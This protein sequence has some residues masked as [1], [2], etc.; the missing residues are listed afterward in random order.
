MQELLPMP[1]QAS[2]TMNRRNDITRLTVDA[3]GSSK[4]SKPTQSPRWRTREYYVYYAVLLIG[5]LYMIAAPL[6][7]SQGRNESCQQVMQ[8]LT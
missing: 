5:T 6:R 3:P 4:V 8:V 7:L 1:A 2:D